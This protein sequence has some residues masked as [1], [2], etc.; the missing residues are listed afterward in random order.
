MSE[1]FSPP[2]LYEFDYKK[3]LFDIEFFPEKLVC[4]HKVYTG[5]REFSEFTDKDE[6]RPFWLQIE[7]TKPFGTFLNK[8][9]ILYHISYVGI[10]LFYYPE[11]PSKALKAKRN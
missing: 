6:N 1:F 7:Y 9:P 5:C 11:H 10:F 8:Q 2:F 3:Y 4:K